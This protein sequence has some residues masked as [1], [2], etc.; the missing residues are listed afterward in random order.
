M[1]ELRRRLNKRRTDSKEQK[2][3]RLDTALHELSYWEKYDYVVL[4]DDLKNAV[5]EVDMIIAAERAKTN[6]KQ[7]KRYWSNAL[8]RL[9]KL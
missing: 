5:N 1:T 4:N 8:A 7:D 9:L 2:M 3:L 6:R